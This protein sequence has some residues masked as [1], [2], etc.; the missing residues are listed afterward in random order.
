MPQ[1]SRQALRNKVEMTHILI[2][3]G[4]EKGSKKWKEMQH[5]TN[6]QLDTE[7]FCNK[8]VMKTALSVV[9]T[10]EKYSPS[11]YGGRDPRDLRIPKKT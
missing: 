11:S 5:F 9:Q 10:P 1:K 6:E 8:W 3:Q 7:Q 2:Q 4:I